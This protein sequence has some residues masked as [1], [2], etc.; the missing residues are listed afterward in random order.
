MLKNPYDKN[1][2]LLKG[3]AKITRFVKEN[4]GLEAIVAKAVEHGHKEGRKQGIEEGIKYVAA[5]L[6]GQQTGKKKKK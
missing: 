2:K 6:M 4:G 5:T 1:G 3:A